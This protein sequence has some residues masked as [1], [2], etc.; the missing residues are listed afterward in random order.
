M[1]IGNPIKRQVKISERRG[2]FVVAT[3][4]LEIVAPS[5]RSARRMG[6]VLRRAMEQAA[7]S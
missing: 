6:V 4:K 7:R 2:S 5:L 1:K 3:D